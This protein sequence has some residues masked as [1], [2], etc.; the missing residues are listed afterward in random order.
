MTV[1]RV[2]PV[3]V[4]VPE[5]GIV[6]AELIV[7]QFA[8]RNWQLSAVIPSIAPM[9]VSGSD[10]FECLRNLKRSSDPAAIRWLCQGARREA[11]A[12]G[13]LRDMGGASKVYITKIGSPATRSDLVPIFGAVAPDA[14][15]TVEEQ[16]SY[17]HAWLNSLNSQEG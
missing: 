15:G 1:K 11:W 12:S 9:V 5:G 4:E 17:H 2:Y 7:E 6:A 10:L 16:D 14:V 8:D 13:M 3:Q